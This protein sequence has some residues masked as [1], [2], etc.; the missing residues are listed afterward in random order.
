MDKTFVKLAQYDDE[1]SAKIAIGEQLKLIFELVGLTAKNWPSNNACKAIADFVYS[2]YKSLSVQ[3]LK[4]AFDLAFQSRL[5]VKTE[6][7]QSFSIPYLASILMAYLTYK[8]DILDKVSD[9]EL[10]QNQIAEKYKNFYKSDRSI[11]DSI[12]YS[13]QEILDEK[14]ISYTF[15]MDNHYQMLS[16]IGMIDFNT[17]EKLELLAEAEEE[18]RIQLAKYQTQI[19]HARHERKDIQSISFVV[20]QIVKN[21]DKE[22][23]ALA[24]SNTFKLQLSRFKNKELGMDVLKD[25]LIGEKTA[26]LCWIDPK[27]EKE[28]IELKRKLRNG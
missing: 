11:K 18:L 20:D 8:K 5:S 2:N 28:I 6:H 13:Y 23:Y 12:L 27:I 21:F 1:I 17:E 9:F 25:K 7:F 22:A 19:K 14:E 15:V 24:K 10:L 4:Y 26:I 16:D 3:E